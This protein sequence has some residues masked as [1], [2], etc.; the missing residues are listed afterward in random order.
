M[1]PTSNILCWIKSLFATT[2][3]DLLSSYK[4]CHGSGGTIKIMVAIQ[5]WKFSE[6]PLQWIFHVII[7]YTWGPVLCTW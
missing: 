4:V 6:K 2:A 1:T 5:L 3:M 7:P